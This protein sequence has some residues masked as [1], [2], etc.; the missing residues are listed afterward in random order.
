M[1]RRPAAPTLHEPA[2]VRARLAE[3]RRQDG[4]TL[5]EIGTDCGLTKSTISEILSGG[6]PTPGIGRVG[7]LLRALRP[8]GR[9][10]GCTWADLD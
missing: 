2:H 4:R 5:D 9:P 1:P 6:I 10:T 7:R 3:L 8:P